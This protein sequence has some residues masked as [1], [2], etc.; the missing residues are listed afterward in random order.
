M[1]EGLNNI[2]TQTCYPLCGHKKL[3]KLDDSKKISILKKREIG[4]E[5]EKIMET[6]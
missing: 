1:L 2:T 5:G 4:I 3:N 6:R